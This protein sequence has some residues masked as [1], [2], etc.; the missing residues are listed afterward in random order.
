M[1]AQAARCAS[2]E[3]DAKVAKKLGI[4]PEFELEEALQLARCL[5]TVFDGDLRQPGLSLARQIIAMY[6]AGEGWFLKGDV[7]EHN[8][9]RLLERASAIAQQQ[10]LLGKLDALEHSSAL[11]AALKAELHDTL[12]QAL[13]SL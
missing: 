5:K 7:A 4:E 11:D 13:A 3:E 9:A 6:A 8:V 2:A 12:S 10:G 1:R